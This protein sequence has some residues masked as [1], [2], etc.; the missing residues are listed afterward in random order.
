[1]L[2]EPRTLERLERLS[3]MTRSKTAGLGGGE[4]RSRRYG[5]SQDFADRRPYVHGDDYRSIDVQVLA[6]SDRLF[7]RL[8]EAEDELDLKLL[9]DTSASMGFHGKL[10]AAERAAGAFAYIAASRRD[11][12]SLYHCDGERVVKGPPMPSKHAAP[13]VFAWLESLSARGPA[14]LTQALTTIHASGRPGMTVLISD[15]LTDQWEGVVR[16]LA[17]SRGD[18][19]LIHVVAQQEIVPGLRGDLSLID[20]E[21]GPSVDVSISADVLAAYTERATTWLEAVAGACRSKGIRYMRWD[22]SVD[23]D[24]GILIGLRTHGFLK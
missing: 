24:E 2:L 19:G 15:L 21:T 11:R 13:S 10:E 3:L 20:P 9:L 4:H 5:S 6:R 16:A 23:I 7:V 1:M 18:A 17:S 12:P 22:P 14:A 8:Y